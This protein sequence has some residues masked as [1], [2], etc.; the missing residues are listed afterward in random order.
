VEHFLLDAD[1][2]ALLVRNWKIFKL[3]LKLH[4]VNTLWQLA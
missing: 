1:S 4:Q 2:P 3:N